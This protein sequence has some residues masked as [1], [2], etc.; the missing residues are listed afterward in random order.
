MRVLADETRPF[1]QGARLTAWELVKDGID[2]TVITD[3][4]AGAIMRAGADRPGGRRRRSHRR[5]RRHRQQDRHL[6]G[7]GAGQGARHP[8]LRRRAVVDHRPGDARRRRHPDRGARRRA[9]SRTSARTQLAP[10]GAHVRNPAFDVTPAQVHHRRS[11]PSA[12]S[13]ARRSTNR[14]GT[15]RPICATPDVRDADPRHRNLLR[16]DRGGASSRDRRCRRARGAMRS[17]VVASQVE[18]HREWGGVVPGAGVAP[19]RARHLRRGRA[20]A[21]RRRR[22]LARRRRAGRHAGPRP[23]RLAAG[24][25]VVR[26]GGGVGARQAARRRQSPRR[27]HRVALA[28]ARRRSRCRPW[29]WSSRAGTPACIWSS[30]E[31]EYQ[32]L[33]RT[34]DDAAGEAYDK[35]AKLL[36]LG[37]PGGP[38]IDRLAREGNDDARSA[39]RARA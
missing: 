35:V 23:G 32:L 14:F 24:R 11:S 29:C 34:R 36:G 10:D 27:P 17:N 7:G 30:T 16:R 20:R 28:R 5:Q 9:K 37:Y 22:D 38:I 25:R 13:I 1:L 33:G 2:T 15:R 21:R 39:G 3:N 19:A 31:G 4:M 26:Q 6:L 12:A 18:I 8:V